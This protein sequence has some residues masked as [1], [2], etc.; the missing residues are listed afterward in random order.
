ML[1]INLMNHKATDQFSGK[2]DGVYRM[3]TKELVYCE[4]EQSVFDRDIVNGGIEQG[5]TY[6]VDNKG[7]VWIQGVHPSSRL[8]HKGML[9]FASAF[10]L[11]RRSL[12]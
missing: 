11:A 2:K 1:V 12:I 10:Y 8:S 6:V 9:T 7:V 4:G 3:L 5:R